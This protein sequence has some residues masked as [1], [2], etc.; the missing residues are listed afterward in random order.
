MRHTANYYLPKEY[1]GKSIEE[2]L[3]IIGNPRSHHDL[4]I[5][6]LLY[7]TYKEKERKVIGVCLK[8][9]NK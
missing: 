6:T 9:I 7:L 1:A 3:E 4:A 2:L 8:I 5:S